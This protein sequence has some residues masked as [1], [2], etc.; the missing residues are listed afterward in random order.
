[1]DQ[2]IYLKMK[3]MFIIMGSVMAAALTSASTLES[4]PDR[5]VPRA[6]TRCECTGVAF[7]EIVRQVYVEQRPLGEILGRTGCAQ[8][9]GACLP[10]L[11]ARLASGR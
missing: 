2:M 7:A 6:M 10:D 4:L 1:M 8:N 5:G 3:F 11:Q 9:C